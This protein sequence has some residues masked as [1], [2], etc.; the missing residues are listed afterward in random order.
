LAIVAIYKPS[1][2]I[3]IEESGSRHY[4]LFWH[5]RCGEEK[6]PFDMKTTRRKEM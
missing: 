3:M 5:S 2:L 4:F 1:Y 6:R